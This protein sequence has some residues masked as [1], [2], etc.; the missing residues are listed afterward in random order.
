[1]SRHAWAGSTGP[2][3]PSGAATSGSAIIAAN[4]SRSSSRQPRIRSRSVRSSGTSAHGFGLR[5]SAS[6]LPLSPVI[7]AG[8]HA[9]NQL[10]R[11]PSSVSTVPDR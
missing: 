11:A 2:S 9:P 1:M 10:S 5:S 6:G 3:W 7:P 4:Q 8:G